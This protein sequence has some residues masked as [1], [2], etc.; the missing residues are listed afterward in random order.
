MAV[1]LGTFSLICACTSR[2]QP[3]APAPPPPSAA[4]P[5]SQQL[6][7]TPPPKLD[8][9]QDAVTRVFKGAA[10]VDSTRNP[11]F[12]AGDFNG[13]GSQD[14]AA[15]I[16]PA[17]GKLAQMNEEFPPW[18]VRDP[19]ITV[20]PG[21]PR[22]RIAATDV[23]LAVIHGYGPNGWRDPQATQTY[24]LKNAVGSDVKTFPKSDFMTANQGKKLPRL[25]GDSI[26]EV[27]RGRSGYLYFAEATY[28]WYDPK[29]FKGE[30]ERRPT[31]SGATARTGP[32]D[33]LNMRVK[34]DIR[35][36]K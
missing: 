30:P 10:L 12:L 8:E 16:K 2:E 17:P 15:I 20:Q 33:L 23:L 34:R 19:F 29:T 27:L 3:K 32:S 21:M 11:H 14:I 35:V 9:V 13:D 24:L 22:L 18:I 25:L 26:G 28:S 6:L 5:P 7:Q 36:E 1:I 31:H 4:A